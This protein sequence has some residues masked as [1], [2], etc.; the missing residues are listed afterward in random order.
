MIDWNQRWIDERIVAWTTEPNVELNEE[1]IVAWTTE[2]NVELN[3][4]RLK[5][6][7]ESE[8]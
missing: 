7:N 6:N 3:E 4:E 1:R 8:E 5:L 2:P